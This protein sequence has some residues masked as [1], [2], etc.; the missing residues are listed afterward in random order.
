MI[1]FHNSLLKEQEIYINNISKWLGK[2]RARWV[3]IRGDNIIFFKTYKEALETVQ[4]KGFAKDPFFI[5][6]VS[7]SF[8]LKLF[9]GLV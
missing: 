1:M 5:E 6:E 7:D 8:Q 3:W 2:H 4:R 9:P